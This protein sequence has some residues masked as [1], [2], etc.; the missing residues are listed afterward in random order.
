MARQFKTEAPSDFYCTKCGQKNLLTVTRKHGQARE[1]GHLKKL[2]CFHCKDEL[3]HAE[4]RE[5]NLNYTYENFKQEYETGRFIDGNRVPITEL[6]ECSC[7]TCPYNIN[8]RCWNANNSFQ[9]RCK[10]IKGE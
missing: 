3:N 8:G 10:P 5:N 4:V 6:I 2:Y 7:L 9:C 1:P